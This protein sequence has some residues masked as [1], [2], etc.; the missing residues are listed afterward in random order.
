[1][2][3]QQCDAT[4]WTVIEHQQ[5]MMMKTFFYYAIQKDIA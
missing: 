2:L 3:E 4:C 1:M 5:E